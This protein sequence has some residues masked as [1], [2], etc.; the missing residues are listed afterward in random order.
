MSVK[1]S[2]IA[3]VAAASV[4][5]Q[6]QPA[7]TVRAE[8]RSSVEG[9]VTNAVTGE[10]LRKAIVT[11]RK[12]PDSGSSN[13]SGPGLPV[14]APYSA[15][16]DAD[17]KYTIDNLDPGKYR[18]STDRIGF[19]AQ[20]YGARSGGANQAGT[21]L[22]LATAQKMKGADFRMIPQAVIVGR[23]LDED[24]DPVQ[25]VNVNCMRQTYVRGRKQWVPLNGHL[26][27][28]LGEYRIHSLAPGRYLLS[29]TY[30]SPMI[31][32]QPA[33]AGNESYAPTYYPAASAPESAAPIEVTAG[34][35][36]RG[37]D[38]RLQ[39]TRT[40]RVRGHVAGLPKKPARSA[41]VR[42]LQRSESFFNFTPQ[43]VRVLDPS[44]DFAISGVAPGSYWLV[45]EAAE[46]NEVTMA[47]IPLEVGSTNIDD[48]TLT[49]ARPG[50]LT[51][52]VKFSGCEEKPS[53][54]RGQLEVTTVGVGFPGF[55]IK[56]DFTFTVKNV[57]PAA[58]RVRLYGI[59]TKCY[60]KGVRFGD[61]ELVD[62]AI[63]L[64]QGVAAGQLTI[65]ISGGAAQVEGSV[66]TD[67]QQPVTSAWV[68][69]IPE[70]SRRDQPDAYVI[71][72]TD[73]NGRYTAK[74]IVPGDYRAYAFD[75]LEA[76][77]YQDREFMKAWEG[78]GEKVTLQE[79]G[80][81]TLQLKAITVP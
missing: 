50:E 26:S 15:T 20:Q 16:T 80:H 7:A 41:A 76:G 11:L 24:G 17:G 18:L 45:A 54:L 44:G 62:S 63:D 31:S 5:A 25:N 34:A 81:E 33:N 6:Q 69:L 30:R 1:L 8:D 58:Y 59:P 32:E 21:M 64:S 38:V 46:D 65:T 13:R 72:S 77:A 27:N 2:L 22:T 29:A 53:G 68:V 43:T 12:I 48:L 23:V 66:E 57:W 52:V 70:G 9:S 28:D 40:V 36:L 3:I 78:R 55:D 60:L 56:D 75:Q 47:R 14:S 4:W 35:Q 79:N 49:L 19:V 74:G 10:P 61:T 42:L 73:Q 51:G 67:K 37:M 71:A 39:K